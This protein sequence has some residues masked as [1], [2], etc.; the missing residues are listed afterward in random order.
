MARARN[1]KPS[2]FTNDTLAECSPLAR[3]LFIGLWTIADCRGRLHDRPKKIKA[4]LLPYDNCDVESLL[5]ELDQYGFILRQALGKSRAILIPAF[6][7][8]QNPHH[9]ERP[10]DFG[11]E[12]NSF[13]NNMDGS[14]IDQPYTGPEQALDQPYTGRAESLLPITESLT[15]HHGKADE[16]TIPESWK[17]EPDTRRIFSMTLDWQPTPA[18]LK[19][20]MLGKPI[21]DSD[22]ASRLAEWRESANASGQTMTDAQWTL[23]LVKFTAKCKASP[24]REP[25]KPPEPQ[26][27]ITPPIGTLTLAPGHTLKPRRVLTPEETQAMLDKIEEERRFLNGKP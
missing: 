4:E 23:R 13:E 19:G 7:K 17:A 26:S 18:T 14:A 10:F 15:P 12:E 3:L 27:T 11:E 6:N 25:E 16:D 20:Y 1:I 21:T 2:F 8:H 24:S 9:K 22:I 5:Q